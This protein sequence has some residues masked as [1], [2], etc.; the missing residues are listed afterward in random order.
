MDSIDSQAA[1]L[2]AQI[3][4]AVKAG[5]REVAEVLKRKRFSVL[6]EKPLKPA[7]PRQ[8]TWDCRAWDGGKKYGWR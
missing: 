3:K 5:D 7:A 1:Q 4:A 2:L 8:M 6:A